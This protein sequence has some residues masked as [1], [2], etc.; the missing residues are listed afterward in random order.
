MLRLPVYLKQPTPPRCP[1]SAVLPA[2]AWRPSR[3]PVTRASSPVP[4]DAVSVPCAPPPFVSARSAKHSQTQSASVLQAVSTQCCPSAIARAVQDPPPLPKT[5]PHTSQSALARPGK[6]VSPRRKAPSSSWA[7]TPTRKQCNAPTR[8]C[9]REYSTPCSFQAPAPPPCTVVLYSF[10]HVTW[11]APPSRP[12]PSCWQLHT[13]RCM[14]F[15][16]SST[17]AY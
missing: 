4:P 15:S 12:C 1:V 3:L 2:C 17:R 5:G 11:T 16:T 7:R 10:F 6:W 8:A 9:I 13:L 14:P